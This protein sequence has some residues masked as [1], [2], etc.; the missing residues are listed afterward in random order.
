[1]APLPAPPLPAL[2]PPP[3]PPPSLHAHGRNLT[4]IIL[5]MSDDQGWGEVG[6]RG[7]RILR[8]PHLAAMAAAGLRLERFY[9]SPVC[10]PTRAAALTGRAADRT[11]VTDQGVP[12]RLGERKTLPRA[13]QAAGWATAHFGKWHLDGLHSVGMGGAP[14]LANGTHGPSAFGFGEWLSSFG[15]FDVD[16][17]LSRNG[18]FE[19]FDGDSSD[20]LVAQAVRWLGAQRA[21]A[22][23]C[24]L[25]LWFASP[26]EPWIALPA[27][28][29]AAAGVFKSRYYG[30]IVALDRSIGTLRAGL[31]RLGVENTTLLWFS[32]D[33]GGY[34][35]LP[36]PANGPL[37]GFKKD[38]FEGGIRVPAIVEWPG[39]IAPGRV[40]WYPSCIY[41]VFP[42]VVDALG[43]PRDA[44][45][46][47]YDGSSLLRLFSRELPRRGKPI[48]IAYKRRW[49][50]I[51][52]E[53]KYVTAGGAHWFYNL[54]R[55]AGNASRHRA[56]AA[57]VGSEDASDESYRLADRRL[58]AANGSAPHAADAVARHV[59]WLRRQMARFMASV[60]AS[61][62]GD[63]YPEGAEAAPLGARV[64][65]DTPEYR[66][67]LAGLLARPQ[68]RP[69]LRQLQ[70]WN[71]SWWP[72]VFR[73]IDPRSVNLNLSARPR[74][75]FEKLG[76]YLRISG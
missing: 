47:P 18:Q 9:V 26:H 3:P 76:G 65:C 41:D 4:T 62:R 1:M 64:W 29:A 5:A 57:A 48:L 21:A 7:H 71:R 42:T 36:V 40:S 49:A 67:H 39:A 25:A 61:Q 51:D 34:H 10:S 72:E 11:G 15:V 14:L 59:A 37:R 22:R 45:L 16:P 8:T 19:D 46:R 30:E 56:A 6:Y 58:A 70:A 74:S 38:I 52:N 13:L 69:E 20:V 66:P 55:A 32:S 33:N 68:F 73:A 53:I 35:G 60:A 24:L 54:S 17:V 31:R 75:R 12:L 23:R 28:R 2:P 44:L 50:L 63:D 43:L 27:D